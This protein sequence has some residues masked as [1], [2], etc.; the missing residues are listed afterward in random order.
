MLFHL[1]FYKKGVDS[2][3]YRP[4]IP[5]PSGIQELN[6][7]NSFNIIP[8]PFSSE[9]H[10]TFSQ[11]QNNSIITITNIL[12][13]VVRNISFSGKEL[14]LARGELKKGMYFVHVEGR[15]S[16]YSAKLMIQ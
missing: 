11:E 2:C 1:I 15:K 8:N 13:E 5:L 16:L 3:G 9:T 10:L 4:I 14:T 6:V 12:G 7:S